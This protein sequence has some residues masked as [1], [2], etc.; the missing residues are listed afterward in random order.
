MT[1]HVSVCVSAHICGLL[2]ET[3]ELGAGFHLGQPWATPQN[4]LPLTWYFPLPLLL[5][6]CWGT[7]T[8]APFHRGGN[9]GSE[10]SQDWPKV[11]Q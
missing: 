8:S 1:T 9:G 6:V 11:T 5:P 3:E 7:G 10:R 4:H 2:C